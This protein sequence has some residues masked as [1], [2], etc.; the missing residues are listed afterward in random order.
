MKKITNESELLNEELRA[1][2]IKKEIYGNENRE[3]K[4]QALRRHEILKNKSKKW[5]M[6]GIEQEGFKRVTVEQMR[7]RASNISVAKKIIGKKSTTYSGGVT[8]KIGEP[9]EAGGKKL[10]NQDQISC[11]LLYDLLNFNTNM[12]KAD[13]FRTGFK[14]G[15]VG[16]VPV[17]DSEETRATGKPKYKLQMR[18]LAPWKYDVIEDPADPTQPLAVIISEFTDRLRFVQYDSVT[19]GAQGIRSGMSLMEHLSDGKDQLIADRAEDKE[20]ADSDRR[21]I[22]WTPSHHFTT[23]MRGRILPDASPENGANPIKKL[24]WQ[25]IAEDQDGGYWADGGDDIFE[26]DIA[27]NK[28]LTDANFI[29]F[30][31]GWGQLVI[32]AENPPK[33]I[34]GGPDNAWIFERTPGGSPASVFYASSN[35]PIENWLEV[36]QMLLALCLSTNNLSPRN[37]S[38]KLS[39]DNTASGVMLMIENSEQ[40]PDIKDSQEYF[41]DIEPALLEIVAAW[42]STYSLNGWLTKPFQEGMPIRNTDLSIKFHDV[43]PPI[44]EKEVLEIMQM[45]KDLGIATMMDLLKKDNPDLTDEEAQAK[46]EEIWA[47]KKKASEFVTGMAKDAQAEGLK[48]GKEEEKEVDDEE[49]LDEESIEA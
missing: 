43:R 2:I 35:P 44:S 11:D 5:V 10:P 46:A 17:L 20:A 30:I 40:T 48:P 27:V 34:I 24:P 16:I 39:V 26:T 21:F 18:V 25:T 45:R 36:I 38:A 1:E 49:E 8:R 15:L 12:R 32:D 19:E 33:T 6:F 41:R 3:R 13:F 29:Q 4:A 42:H 7:S 9:I 14:N 47:E 22:W 23:D 31:Q 28:K 37:V